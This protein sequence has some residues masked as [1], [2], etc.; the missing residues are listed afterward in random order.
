MGLEE[1]LKVLHLD[2]QRAKRSLGGT[3][4]IGDLKAYTMTLFLQQGHTS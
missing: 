3:R 1:G 4:A 2:S